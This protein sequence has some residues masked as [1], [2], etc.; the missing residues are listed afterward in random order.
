[1][2][3]VAAQ[4]KAKKWISCITH[5]DFYWLW[6]WAVIE[7]VIVKILF[8]HHTHI[9]SI[10]YKPSFNCCPVLCKLNSCISNCNGYYHMILHR[11]ILHTTLKGYWMKFTCY[12]YERTEEY[13][14]YY[15]L[16]C[17]AIKWINCR[18]LLN[19]NKCT[20]LHIEDNY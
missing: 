18:S 15:Q 4:G 5:V 12:V 7:P 20:Y 19:F 9:K 17:F 2:D 13:D 3:A 16:V 6:W 14:R 8:S 11:D 10:S 1:M